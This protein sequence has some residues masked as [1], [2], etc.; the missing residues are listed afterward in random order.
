MIVLLLENRY[1]AGSE[2]H[3]GRPKSTPYRHEEVPREEKSNFEKADAIERE[4]EEA[5]ERHAIITRRIQGAVAS[6]KKSRQ[7]H[8]IFI[9]S[10]EKVPKTKIRKTKS[11]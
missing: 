10:R 5:Q 11:S 4:Q 6:P 2:G 8:C 7:N 3:V 1:F 9:V